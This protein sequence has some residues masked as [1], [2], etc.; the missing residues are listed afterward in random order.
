MSQ[1][2]EE[3]QEMGFKSIFIDHNMSILGMLRL[4]DSDNIL[5]SSQDSLWKCRDMLIA[6][7][8]KTEARDICIHLR[9]QLLDTGIDLYRPYLKEGVEFYLW[10]GDSGA[11]AGLLDHLTVV[12]S[13]LKN[14]ARDE[15]FLVIQTPTSSRILA[16]W[17][18]ADN[19][20]VGVLVTNPRTVDRVADQLMAI[21]QS[22]AR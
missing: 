15:G 11:S 20:I 22:G 16:A 1:R 17:K 4:Y 10:Q 14:V 9:P 18:E 2:P 19:R 5:I 12:R 6:R 21:I 3:R 13:R 8:A 7:L